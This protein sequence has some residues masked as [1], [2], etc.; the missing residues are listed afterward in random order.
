MARIRIL[1]SQLIDK[2]A[3]GEVVERPA[4]VVKELVENAIDAGARQITIQIAKAGK[5]LIRVSDD[6]CGMDAADCRLALERHA[7]SKITDEK[8]LFAIATLGFRGEALPSIASVSQLT[9]ET[10]T[11]AALSGT[12]VVL[13][14]GAKIEEREAGCPQG[15]DIHV[16]RLFY[17]TPAR[18]KFLKS[19]GVELGHIEEV[20]VRLAIGSP[21]IGF[22]YCVDG[23]TKW[24]AEAA[25][26]PVRRMT[27]LLP[28]QWAGDWLELHEENPQLT[29]RGWIAHPRL[30]L[31]QPNHSYFYLNGRFLKDRVLQHALQAGFDDY[32][33]RGRYPV[34]VLYLKIDPSQVDVNVHPAKRE[35]RFQN[36]GAVHDFIMRS[37][38]KGLQVQLHGAT[39]PQVSSSIDSLSPCG[40]G[41]GRGEESVPLPLTPSHQGRE[42]LNLSQSVFFTPGHYQSLRVLGQLAQTYIVCESPQKELVLIDQHAAH[43][44]IGYDKL[45]KMMREQKG[46]VQHLL[47]PFTW[48]VTAKEAALIESRLDLL[49]QAGLEIEPFGGAGREGDR[50][51]AGA[52]DRSSAENNGLPR[53]GSGP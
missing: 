36:S 53:S 42:N 26:D 47:V 9:V 34:A 13:Q 30:N 44:R 2:I 31:S 12:R 49:Q 35:V 10:K 14:G 52:G 38:R 11:V 32:L 37:V 5:E 41:L 1:P 15:T 23:K 6:G 19:D 48:E 39:P 22:K 8:D 3:A 29:V 4:S 17:N 45:K 27:Q 50:A 43:E 21:E 40:R 25:G 28:S 18:L 24:T 20:V 7:T 33:M 16:A 51:I 46:A